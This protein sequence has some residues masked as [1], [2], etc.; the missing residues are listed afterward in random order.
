[1]P[2][3]IRHGLALSKDEAMRSCEWLETNVLQEMF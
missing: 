3:A 2:Y 1:M